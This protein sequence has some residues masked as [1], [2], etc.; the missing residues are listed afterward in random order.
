[1]ILHRTVRASLLRAA[2]LCICAG[3]VLGG[4]GLAAVPATAQEAA[5]AVQ[6]V[7]LV[8]VALPLG[9]TLFKAARVR[10]SGTRLSRGDLTAILAPDSAEPWAPRLARL[11]AASISIPVLVSEHPGPGGSLQTVTYREVTARDV[12]A[13]RIAEL[14]MAGAGVAVSGAQKGSGTYGRIVAS[15]LD[16][17][18]LVRLSSEP[19]DGKGPVQRVYAAIRVADVTYTEDSGVAI[20]IAGLE[21]RDFGGRQI[22]GGWNGA[23]AALT[24]GLDAVD[25]EMKADARG[26][27]AATAADLADA[28]SFGSLELHGLAISRTGAGA[29]MLVEVGR[30]AHVGTG[31]EAGT[32]LEAIAF[33]QGGVKA[34]LARAALT[35]VSLSPTIAALRRLADPNA[36]VTDEAL[37]RLTPAIGGL[38]LQDMSIELP[39]DPAAEARQ[40]GRSAGK[41][42]AVA[43]DPLG[44]PAS[45]GAAPL[46]LVLRSGALTFGPLRD[47]V[48]TASRLDLSGLAFPATMVAGVPVLGA[49]PDYGY[50]DLDLNLV[51]D[52]AWDEDKREVALREMTLSG[53]D[54]GSLRLAGTIGGM[55]PELFASHIPAASLLMLTATA[56]ALDLTVQNTGL[57]ERFL[58]AQAKALSLKPEELRQEYVAATQFGVPAMLGN[59]PAARAI[60]SAL[61]QFVTKPGRLTLNA[62][63]KNAAGLGF[64]DFGLARTPGAVLDKLD[65]DAR[66]E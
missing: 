25:P 15:D 36:A 40:T 43:G 56:K 64:A 58:A 8:D 12:R 3:L 44:V 46:R 34:R 61:G 51:V 7:V 47:G 66:V 6:D 39:A 21:G 23:M 35:G 5:S 30:L 33:A 9:D 57:F 55:G 41:P 2:R 50:A 29:P 54:I 10:V 62:K 31:A 11:E 20:R 16:L 59:S 24:R 37:R 42:P 28:V 38:T 22:P 60:G 26:R 52:S 49:L 14:T 53:R 4:A 27:L 65:V 48:P 19:G 45:Q 13:G 32:T 17:A 1:M 63:A 18:A